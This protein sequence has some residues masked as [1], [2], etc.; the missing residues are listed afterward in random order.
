MTKDTITL[1]LS[2]EEADMLQ[3]AC[4]IAIERNK[5]LYERHGAD[6]MR[7]RVEKF[8]KLYHKIDT[9]ANPL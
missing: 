1:K 7:E 8:R 9:R 4:S 3:V 2:R 5:E 6:W